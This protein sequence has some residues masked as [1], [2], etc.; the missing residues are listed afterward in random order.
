MCQHFR[1]EGRDATI[2]GVTPGQD[3]I[4]IPTDSDMTATALILTSEASE[5]L[6]Q[7]LPQENCK[8]FT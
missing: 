1:V 7:S 8:A 2:L 4:A 6:L 5:A 3:Y